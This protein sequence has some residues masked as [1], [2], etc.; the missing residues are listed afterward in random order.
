MVKRFSGRISDSVKQTLFATAF[1][2]KTT[3]ALYLKIYNHNIPQRGPNHQTPIQG[4]Q[5]WRLEKPEFFVKRVYKHAG[6]GSYARRA[7][8]SAKINSLAERYDNSCSTIA[9]L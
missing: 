1:E 4:L 9:I 2:L 6:L 7:R 8:L 3:L 5:K